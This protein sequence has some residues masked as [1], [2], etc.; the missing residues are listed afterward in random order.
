[1][2]VCFFLLSFISLIPA[3]QHSYYGLFEK[4]ALHAAE[5]SNADI[6]FKTRKGTEEAP[7]HPDKVTLLFNTKAYLQ[8]IIDRSKATGQQGVYDYKGV[9]ISISEYFIT[10][11]IFFFSLLMVTPGKLTRKLLNLLLGGL[12]IIGFA[13]LTVRFRVN[14]GIAEAGLPGMSFGPREFK[15]YKL[16]SFALSSVTTITVVLLLWGLLAF[17]KSELRKA[18]NWEVNE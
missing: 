14:F 15:A 12:L 1:M 10:P 13:Y 4:I 17:R 6:Y 8:T 2:I 11:L 7:N 3:V 9:V 18:F 16:L 5:T